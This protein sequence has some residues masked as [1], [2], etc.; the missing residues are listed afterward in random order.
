MQL[1]DEIIKY[2]PGGQ[3]PIV[4]VPGSQWVIVDAVGANWTMQKWPEG[5]AVAFDIHFDA[6]DPVHEFLAADK[7]APFPNA[8]KLMGAY[9]RPFERGF[10]LRLRRARDDRSIAE[11]MRPHY[12]AATALELAGMIRADPYDGHLCDN[13]EYYPDGNAIR[14]PQVWRDGSFWV[15][16]PME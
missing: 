12:E 16:I 10:R 7:W 15:R 5:K 6:D 9:N 13:L 4:R 8:R 14:G 2:G 1:I 11:V 3:Y